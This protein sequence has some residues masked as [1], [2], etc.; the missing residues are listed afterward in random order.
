MGDMQP[1]INPGLALLEAMLAPCAKRDDYCLRAY[2]T[3]RG[4]AL[5]QE[6]NC[7]NTHWRHAVRFK[8][9]SSLGKTQQHVLLQV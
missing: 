1:R 8:M 4:Q 3:I 7:R 5:L 9:S 2:C 6:L